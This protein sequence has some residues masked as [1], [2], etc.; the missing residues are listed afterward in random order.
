M[1]WTPTEIKHAFGGKLLGDRFTKSI[2]SETLAK[3][4]SEIIEYTIA[5][6]IGHIILGHKN[7]INYR[8]TKSE[9]SQQE[10]E[11]DQFANQI[12]KSIS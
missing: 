11:A 8:Q 1:K 12:L 9:V 6:E 4:P 5:H 10:W 3:F 2:V 7:S